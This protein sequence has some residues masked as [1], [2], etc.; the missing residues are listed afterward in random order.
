MDGCNVNAWQLLRLLAEQLPGRDS[1]G[2]SE[3]E[4]VVGT[5][6]VDALHS[7]AQ[8]ESFASFVSNAITFWVGKAVLDASSEV[9]AVARSW[10]YIL[11]KYC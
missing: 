9:I 11:T 3:I 8:C 4:E 6:I 7:Q 1:W 10:K 5:L 2:T